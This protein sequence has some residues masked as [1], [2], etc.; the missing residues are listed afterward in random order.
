MTDQTEMKTGADLRN[1][2][3]EERN[4]R[5]GEMDE[6]LSELQEKAAIIRTGIMNAWM[7]TENAEVL[8][9]YMDTDWAEDYEASNKEDE[10][11]EFP[12]LSSGLLNQDSLY[13]EITDYYQL[14][15]D[16][17]QAGADLVRAISP[18]TD[19]EKAVKEANDQNDGQMKDDETSD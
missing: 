3:Y 1:E 11:A 5:L 2:T 10:R 8:S 6:R 12:I 17:I 19:I 15:I 9:E 14:G 18:D 16:L 7:M 13:N 4:R